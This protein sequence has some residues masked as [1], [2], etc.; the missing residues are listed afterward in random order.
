M[1]HSS[2]HHA[3]CPV[4]PVVGKIQA[5]INF[6]FSVLHSLSLF[7]PLSLYLPECLSARTPEKSQYV[8]ECKKFN[9]IEFMFCLHIPR[10]LYFAGLQ[11]NA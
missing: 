10:C 3:K 8:I 2:A 1:I 6:V 11:G 7:L 9:I 4:L 5:S